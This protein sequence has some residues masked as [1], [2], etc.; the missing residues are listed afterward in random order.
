MR[1]IFHIREKAHVRASMFSCLLFRACLRLY[2]IN[3]D[4]FPLPKTCSRLEDVYKNM[5]ISMA[6]IRH[7]LTANNR[8][9]RRCQQTVALESNATPALGFHHTAD[10]KTIT[11]MSR[12]FY[13]LFWWIIYLPPTNVQ[14]LFETNLLL[15]S[16]ISISSTDIT[17][18]EDSPLILRS[19]TWLLP[20]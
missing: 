4:Y 19:S 6:V 8:P 18:K 15:S 17:F 2:W 1:N 13:L 14:V 11:I 12:S 5:A 10:I 20:M 16:K 3:L 7:A 9:N